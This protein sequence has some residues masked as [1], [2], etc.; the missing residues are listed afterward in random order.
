[1]KQRDFHQIRN[2]NSAIRNRK[3]LAVV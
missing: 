3:G 1:M 2:P